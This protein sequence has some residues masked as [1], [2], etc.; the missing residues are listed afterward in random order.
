MCGKR[1]AEWLKSLGICTLNK[2]ILIDLRTSFLFLLLFYFPYLLFSKKSVLKY[3]VVDVGLE[4][5]VL[6][7]QSLKALDYRYVHHTQLK[8]ET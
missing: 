3:Y 8:T 7:P 1:S 6:L 4:L 2:L 5:M